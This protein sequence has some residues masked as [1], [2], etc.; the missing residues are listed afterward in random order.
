MLYKA[1]LFSISILLLLIPSYDVNAQTQSGVKLLKTFGYLNSSQHYVVF[2]EVVNEGSPVQFVEIIVQFFDQELKP[3]TTTSGSLGIEILNS[4]QMSP[5]TT[6]LNDEQL[7][8]LVKSFTITIGNFNTAEE[9]TRKLDVIFHKIETSG[10]S[11]TISGRIANDG[12]ATSD[13]TKAMVVLY[14]AVGEPVRYAFAFTEPRN[15][16]P[17]S[18]GTFS[19]KMNVENL[20]TIAGYAIY[21]ESSTYSEVSRV[22]KTEEFQMTRVQET[23]N[24]T[25]LSVLNQ[26]NQPVNSVAFG[27]P[28]LFMV[29]LANNILERHQYM[30]ILQI[31]D[32][33]GFVVSLSWAIDSLEV[34]ESSSA[35]I[36]WVPLESGTYEAEAFIWNNLE[37]AVP[38]SFRTVSNTLMVT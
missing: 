27:Q 1:V 31:K 5:F 24:L 13:N 23:V 28:V 18:S 2:G 17:F 20:G 12:S 35:T 37:E 14:N 11:V 19:I 8:P 10:D 15:V 33:N 22:L 9:K 38:L 4:G 34:R 36:A 6:V 25:E 3:L 26:N 7:A 32:H 29:S 30:Y 21:S 16:L